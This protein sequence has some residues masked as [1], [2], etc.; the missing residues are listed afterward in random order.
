M[1][2]ERRTIIDQIEIRR[3]GTVHVRLAKQVIDGEE[4][5]RSEYHRFGV[6]PGADLESCL[7]VVNAH[8]TERR[9][10]GVESAEWDRVRRVVAM[11][12]T[13]EAVVAYREKRAGLDANVSGG[14]TS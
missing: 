6:E 4:V 11:A 7:P 13:P 10:A 9:E 2:L 1:S 12:H 14:K 3:D 8:L 5:L